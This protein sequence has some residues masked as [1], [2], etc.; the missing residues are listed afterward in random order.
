MPTETLRPNTTGSSTQF[1]PSAGANWENVDEVS[2]DDDT[3]TVRTPPD[4]VWKKDLYNLPASG[5]SGTISKIKVYIRVRDDWISGTHGSIII[6]IKSGVT[7]VQSVSSSVGVIWTTKSYEWATDPNTSSPWTWAAIDALEI[8]IRGKGNEPGSVTTYCTQ[9]Y[10]EVD[11]TALTSVVV[12][13]TTLSLALTFYAPTVS[14]SSLDIDSYAEANRDNHISI[15]ALH[16]SAGAVVSALG[17]S[18]TGDGNKLGYVK[19]HIKKVGSPVGELTARVYTLSGTFGTSS[20]PVGAALASS[21]P[22]AIED[23]G[24]GDF[25]LVTF[26]FDGSFT[27]A[28]GSQRC[29]ICEVSSVTL[30]D[31]SNYIQIGVDASSPTHGGNSIYYWNSGWV[32][33]DAWDTIFYVY[34]VPV[35]ATPTTLALILTT[36]A[37]TVSTPVLV[38]PTTL[39][40]TLSTF[41][42]SI[43]IDFKVIPATLVLT[44]TSYAPSTI[45][46]YIFTPSTL[47]LLLTFYAPSLTITGRQLNISIITSQYRDIKTITTQNKDIKTITS[48]N[49]NIETITAGG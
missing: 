10:V 9:V 15:K 36:Y 49:K 18:F 23:I 41:A 14:I 44:L 31:T 32:D 3:T 30:F 34:A 26:T 21:S 27:V 42:P 22:M 33:E 12:T 29:I 46:G 8:G 17:Q 43:A 28:N 16:P 24:A 38:T 35:L 39:A 40:L 1:I 4:S 48:Q 37:P 6:R 47:A 11:Y 7:E 20:V 2:A 25:E 45:V 13:P 5:G 19:F